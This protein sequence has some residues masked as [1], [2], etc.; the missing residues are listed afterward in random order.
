MSKDKTIIAFKKATSDKNIT[1]TLKSPIGRIWWKSKLAKEIINLFPKHNHYIEV[2][3]WWMSILFSK[4]ESKIETVND[5]N[6]DLINLWQT[7]KYHPQT[8]S[9]YLYQLFTSREIFKN[10]KSWKYKPSHDIERAAFFYYLISQS[11]WS[12][13][14]H[15][16]MSS[17]AGRKPKNLYK[18]FFK[19]TQRLK[20]VTIENMSFENL[21][22]KYDTSKDTF[23]YLDPP[24]YNFE[25]CYESGFKKELH[26]LLRDTLKNIKGKF[27][28][29]YND[30]EEIRELY[31]DFY[32]K[33]S[34]EISYTL[35]KNSKWE[36]KK[37]TELYI[38]NYK[39]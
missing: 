20:F 14:K 2:F 10:I 17:K 33:S 23:F 5:I 32:I 29:S 18:N 3:G 30:C 7:I 28:L 38:S 12:S 27:L 39:I 1:T 37:V 25:K 21:I 9:H 34:K 11:F 19:W 4:Q 8:L 35:W 15:F 31:K 22:T 36:H 13:W 16:A 6:N 26:I 24:Y